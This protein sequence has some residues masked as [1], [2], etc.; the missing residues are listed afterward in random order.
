MCG[1]KFVSLPPN[2]PWARGGVLFPDKEAKVIIH[3][4]NEKDTNY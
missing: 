3:G 4:K 2:F 1:I